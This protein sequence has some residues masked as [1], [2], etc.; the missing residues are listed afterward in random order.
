MIQNSKTKGP[1]AHGRKTLCPAPPRGRLC[2]PGCC[3]RCPA[4][5]WIFARDAPP[6]RRQA[7]GLSPMRPWAMASC[8]VLLYYSTLIL[9]YYIIL[10][11]FYRAVL[12]CTV[13]NYS[14]WIQ[15][16]LMGGPI[17]HLS[18][19]HSRFLCP[20]YSFARSSQ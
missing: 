6:R 13:R 11:I 1:W 15:W 17:S 3:F 12:F 14:A 18:S 16:P 8:S 4:K 20:R 9:Y 2:R 7:Q 5:C 19:S 10:Y